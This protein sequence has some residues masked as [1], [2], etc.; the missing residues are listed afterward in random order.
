MRPQTVFSGLEALALL[1]DQR[2][3]G[4]PF[5]IAIL[6]MGMPE[7]NGLM[8]ASAI[9]ADASLAQT[10]L[11]MLSSLGYHGTGDGAENPGIEEFLIKPIKQAKLYDSLAAV[12]QRRPGSPTQGPALIA[13]TTRSAEPPVRVPR[14][15]ARILLAEDNITNQKVA[16]MLLAKLGYSADT[17]AD[18]NEV[19]EALRR[20]PYDI[21]LMDCQ[22]PELDGYETTRRIRQTDT[23]PIHII[24]MT[25]HAMEGDREKCLAAGMND[26]ISKPVKSAD[27]EVALGRWQQTAPH[28]N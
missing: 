28:R 7:M 10:R 11:V 12:M 22:M 24:A 23:R 17:V 6:D 16:L 13:L 14:Q 19:L 18:G 20:I 2:A 26:Y 8:L 27:I 3:K 4:D 25:A 9:K 21:I 1:A 5:D 15:A